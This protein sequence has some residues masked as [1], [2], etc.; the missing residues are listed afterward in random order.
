MPSLDEE[1]F[2][3]ARDVAAAL[4]DAADFGEAQ[5]R[6]LIYCNASPSKPEVERIL[7][8]GANNHTADF[9]DPR[10]GPRGVDPSGCDFHR[11]RRHGDALMCNRVA[12]EY[13][14][15][16][17]A[18]EYDVRDYLDE[19]PGLLERAAGST[20]GP[21]NLVPIITRDGRQ[22]VVK[23]A[24]WWYIPSW[25]KTGKPDAR[26]TFNARSDKIGEPKSLFHA[27]FKSRRCLVP[28]TAF[29]AFKGGTGRT[30]TPYLFSVKD[31]PIFSLAGLWDHWEPGRANS[32]ETP[33][34]HAPFDSFTVITTDANELGLPIHD[35]MPVII[36]RDDYARWL[37]PENHDFGA[38]Q[39]LLVP[40]VATR[41]S[42]M[43]QPRSA[44]TSSA[45]KKA[46]DADEEPSVQGELF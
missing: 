35:R 31:R 28:V 39:K 44:T 11:V 25:S 24:S 16:E 42:V 21:A 36:D 17:L 41:M 20:V 26:A 13:K 30:K 29:Y 9:V 3:Y 6:M 8:E 19:H 14:N 7:V 12:K 27:S 22:R 10:V 15:A 4:D 40:F 33:A 37:D 18:D 23:I 43:E 34:D 2:A 5:E 45:A 38:L 46:R 1:V 32:A